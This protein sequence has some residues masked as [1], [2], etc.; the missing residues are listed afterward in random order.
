MVA[1]L[2]PQRLMYEICWT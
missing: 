2:R 1:F